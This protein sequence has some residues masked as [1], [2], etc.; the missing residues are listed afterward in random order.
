ML[1]RSEPYWS[2][3]LNIQSGF[4]NSWPVSLDETGN[5]GGFPITRQLA[6]V[7]GS[8]RV[9]FPFLYIPENAESNFAVC[10][11]GDTPTASDAV[12]QIWVYYQHE[13]S[14]LRNENLHN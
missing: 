1:S 11:L 10:F 12:F 6:E 5:G 14:W 4:A 9:V 3:A 8:I 7:N 2:G 13:D